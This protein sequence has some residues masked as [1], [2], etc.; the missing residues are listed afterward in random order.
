MT[1][2]STKSASREWSGGLR[3][4]DAST[5]DAFGLGGMQQTAI[6]HADPGSSGACRLKRMTR[7]TTTR[8]E[9]Q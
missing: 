3:T 4:P 6:I 8:V 7:A 1:R 5:D 9:G 2:K